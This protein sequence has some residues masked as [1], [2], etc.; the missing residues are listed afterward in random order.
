MLGP[1]GRKLV[2]ALALAS[3]SCGNKPPDS[4]PEGAVRELCDHL[5]R[6]DGSPKEAKAAFALLAKETRDNLVARA[7]RYSGG[8]GKHIEPEMMLAPASFTERFSARSLESVVHGNYAIVRARGLLEEDR[9]EIPCVFEDGG[10]KVKI[11]LPPLPPVVVRPRE[12]SSPTRR[13]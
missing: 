13:R 12:D 3:I 10:W 8:S 2:A 6:L 4:T 11:D 1:H 7:E 5:R 9:A